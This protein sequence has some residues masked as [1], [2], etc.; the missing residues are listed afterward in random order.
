MR[1]NQFAI[2]L[3]FTDATLAAD[4][5]GL[6]DPVRLANLGVRV[7]NAVAERE[8]DAAKDFTTQQVNLSRGYVDGAMELRQAR[9]PT[10]EATVAAPMRNVTLARFDAGV[11]AVPVRWSNARIEGMGKKFSKWPGWTRRKGDPLRGVDEDYKTAGVDVSVKRGGAKEIGRA[12]MLPLRNSGGRLGVFVHENGGLKHLYG[13]A[14]YQIY[15][16]YLTN[17]EE[18]IQEE[19]RAD[20]VAGLD[21][22]IAE[23]KL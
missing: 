12:F 1:I 5:L 9:L 7:V 19:L 10:A 16:T 4:A 18:R 13:P 17:N 3:D 21:G 6:L 11:H 23:S 20:Y 22:L 8:H 15:R 2:G 14:V